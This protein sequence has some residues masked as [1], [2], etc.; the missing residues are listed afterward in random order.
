MVG[1]STWGAALAVEACDGGLGVSDAHE[2][3]AIAIAPS[4]PATNSWSIRFIMLFPETG[5]MPPRQ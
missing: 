4:T 2:I 5:S 3:A 1:G